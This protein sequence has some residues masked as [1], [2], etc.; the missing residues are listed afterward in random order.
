MIKCIVNKQFTQGV[1][2][3]MS[4]YLVIGIEF[5]YWKDGKLMDT[6]TDWCPNK[7]GPS[8]VDQIEELGNYWWD[9]L[10]EAWKPFEIKFVKLHVKCV[11]L[12][13]YDFEKWKPSEKNI[14]SEG[15]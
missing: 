4:S 6:I 1:C 7:R 8:T 9:R 3:K 10:T 15:K 13:F 12:Q 5:E 11:I 2:M 14:E